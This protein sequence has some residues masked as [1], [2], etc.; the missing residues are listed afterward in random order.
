[1]GDWVDPHDF[2]P[3]GMSSMDVSGIVRESILIREGL[4]FNRR[5]II[6]MVFVWSE[7]QGHLTHWSVGHSFY[8]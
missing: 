7:V 8:Q 3:F 4:L 6:R 2:L 1:M 5:C